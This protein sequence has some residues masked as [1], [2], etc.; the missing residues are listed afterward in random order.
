MANYVKFLR[1][2]VTA[3][4]NLAN[5]DKDTLYFV[6]ENKDSTTGKLYLGSVELSGSINESGIVDYLSELKDVDTAGA[7]QNN[8]LGF[9]GT[10]WVPMDVNALV[11]VSI[12]GGANADVAGTAGLVPAPAAGEENYFLR[13]DGLWAPITKHS[14]QIFEIELN[15]NEA[16]EDAIVRAVG[17]AIPV[18]GDFVIIKNANERISYIYN[19]IAWIALNNEYLT[20]IN[21]L[22][23]SIN[24]IADVLTG[25]NGLQNQIDNLQSELTQDIENLN[26]AVEN[27][28]DEA[29]LETLREAL[30]NK[31]EKSELDNKANVN[32]IYTKQEVNTAIATA[33]SA[34][35]HLK[36][37]IVNEYADIQKY[38]EEHTDAD[39]YIFM[40]PTIYQYMS[41]SNKYDEYIVLKSDNDTYTIEPVGSWSVS[42]EDY[43]NKT[44][45]N[46]KFVAKE[47]GKGLVNNADIE[48]LS[49]IPATAEENYIKNVNEEQFAVSDAG[50]LSLTPAIT[51]ALLTESDKTKL[52]ALIFG[53]NNNI[54]ISGKVNAFNVED[55][56]VWIEQNRNNI[57]GLLSIDAQTKIDN[58][59]DPIIYSVN[60]DEF[61][62]IEDKQLNLASVPLNKVENLADLLNATD[63]AIENL[64]TK[65]LNIEEALNN[66]VLKDSLDDQLALINTDLSTLK[67][68][69]QWGTLVE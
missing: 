3:Y 1:G 41:E 30:E 37:K 58:I 2:T 47:D 52:N 63:N 12:M 31:A 69:M 26:V 55:L 14:V 67:Q 40:V 19:G 59:V 49:S 25:D 4:N 60:P 5:K 46:E 48:K 50:E 11:Q 13:G 56:N 43:Y 33:V 35:D 62:L 23:N 24:D 10:K 15:E 42:L 61:T 17:E 53:E 54:E 36:R 32:D 34:A 64:D 8:I 21:E 57:N 65:V 28:A 16:H 44:E 27:K 20:Y 68:A 45:I 9:N 7:V 29:D 18:V 66:Y 51:N 39:Q 22:Q 38:I 6:T